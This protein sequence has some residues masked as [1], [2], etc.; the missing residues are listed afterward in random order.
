MTGLFYEISRF[1]SVL[2][3]MAL[4]MKC[5]FFVVS[6][7]SQAS[8]SPYSLSFDRCL[9]DLELRTL[10]SEPFESV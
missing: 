2:E 10:Q 8:M 3:N 9:M 6:S 1:K 7:V 4:N 5:W